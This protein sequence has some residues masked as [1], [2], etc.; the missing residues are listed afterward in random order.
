MNHSIASRLRDLLH[1][2]PFRPFEIRM[3]DGSRYLV[4]HEDFLNVTRSGSVIYD[5]G[6][7]VYKTLNVTLISEI[8]EKLATA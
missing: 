8:D 3:V 2:S 5:D 1:T 6:N 4:P 7:S